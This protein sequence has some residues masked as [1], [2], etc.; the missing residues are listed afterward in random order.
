LLRTHSANDA[1]HTPESP[2]HPP[3]N[4]AVCARWVSTTRTYGMPSASQVTPQYGP[5]ACL[6]QL[7]SGGLLRSV[8]GGGQHLLVRRGDL[9]GLPHKVTALPVC[10]L[11][12]GQERVI[13]AKEART[14]GLDRRHL[15][16]RAA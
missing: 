15:G 13:G 12:R 5:V 6:G 3:E 14:D 7:E 16:R 10:R 1:R 11:A 4:I 9:A 2:R 8:K